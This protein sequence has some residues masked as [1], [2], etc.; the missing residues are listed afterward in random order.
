[1]FGS[2]VIKGHAQTGTKQ[3]EMKLFSAQY[4]KSAAKTKD[5]AQLISISE[6]KTRVQSQIFWRNKHFEYFSV[7]VYRREESSDIT[8][9]VWDLK[10]WIYNHSPLST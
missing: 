3:D 6:G 9:N 1:M 10:R 7:S 4:A 8:L 2:E 5:V